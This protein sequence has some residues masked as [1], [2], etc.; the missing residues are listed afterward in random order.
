MYCVKCGKVIA[1]NAKF[2]LACG[3]PVET[4]PPTYRSTRQSAYEAPSDAEPESPL[5]PASSEGDVSFVQNPVGAALPVDPYARANSVISGIQ[6]PL[7]NS[8]PAPA[9]EVD[10]EGDP[11]AE[12]LAKVEGVPFTLNAREAAK[13]ASAP[14]EP[15]RGYYRDANVVVRDYFVLNLISTFCCC[16]PIGAVGTF[17][18]WRTM[19]AKSRGDS[20]AAAKNAEGAAFCFWT[21]VTIAACF[22]LVYGAQAMLQGLVDS[23]ALG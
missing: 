18:S 8:A 20:E 19:A 7:A 5:P 3:A 6:N 13:V 17:Y 4:V 16:L 2:C 10:F 23:L 1:D 12:Y 22:A 14:R 21:T 15:A 9:D 11:E